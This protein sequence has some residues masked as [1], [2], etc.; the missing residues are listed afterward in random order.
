MGGVGSTSGFGS[1]T[2]PA[3]ARAW[4]ISLYVMT[5][6]WTS[7]ETMWKNKG[8]MS[9]NVCML[10]L[11]HLHSHKKIGNLTFW[12]PLINIQSNSVIY[13]LSSIFSKCGYLSNSSSWGYEQ[14][15]FSVMP[16]NIA[17]NCFPKVFSVL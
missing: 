12:L 11:S 7:L 16:G 4:K 6:T 14:S 3:T 5:S 10:S 13:T 9:K 8:L 1:R 17:R 15:A 2:S